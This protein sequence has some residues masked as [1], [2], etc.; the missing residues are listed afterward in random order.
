MNFFIYYVVPFIVVLGILIFFH[1]LGHFLV[2]KYFGV[3]VLKF[4][5]G[6]GYKLIGKQ[7]GETEYIISTVPLGGYVKMLGENDDESESLSVAESARSFNNQTV[8][9]RIAIVAAG[10]FFNLLLALFLFCG[11]Y[12]VSGIHVM[13]TEVGQVRENSPA[14]KA[15]F[16]KGDIIMAVDGKD[17]GSWSEIKS[18]VQK[19]AGETMTI[20]VQRGGKFL[21]LTVVPET[22]VEKNLFGEEIKSALIGIVAAGTYK[23]VELGPRSAVAEA[24]RKTWEVTSLTCLTIVKLFQRVIP[25]KTLGGPILI[26]QMTGQLAREN[27]T[28]LIPFMAVISVNLAV[29]NLLPVP[30]LD[31]GVILFLLIELIIGKP[32]SIRKRDLAQKFGLFLLLLLMA[33]VFYNDITRL[34]E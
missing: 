20:V 13:T 30:I 26:G 19:R 28:Y 1:E 8:F 34:L 27:I 4:S 15:G 11:L 21:S 5:L 22:S 14:E 32:I 33:V 29:L 10:P 6:F 17:I 23:Q 12:L 7:I 24:F 18:Q 9:R 31:G 2:A 3:K 16:Q 25:I